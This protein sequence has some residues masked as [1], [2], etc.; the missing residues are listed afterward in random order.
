MLRADVLAVLVFG[1]VSESAQGT[2]YTRRLAN[3]GKSLLT[4]LEAA[5]LRPGPA[6]RGSTGGTKLRQFT[7]IPSLFS[8]SRGCW[9]CQM[10]FLHELI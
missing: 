4:V 2:P 8:L 5:S 1:A 6:W 7:F 3:R 10:S 9:I